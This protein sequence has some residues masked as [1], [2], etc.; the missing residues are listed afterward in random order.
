ME[1][2]LKLRQAANL[3]GF[4]RETLK[5]WIKSGHGP[6]VS[7]TPGGRYLFTESALIE[8]HNSLK[9]VEPVS[10]LEQI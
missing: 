2:L 5:R 4:H 6:K 7:R 1:K 10:E 3:I 8:W 9:V